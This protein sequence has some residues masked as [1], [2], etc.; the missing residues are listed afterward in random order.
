[1]TSSKNQE[2]DDVI[3]KSRNR[4]LGH[5]RTHK[6]TESEAKGNSLRSC[7]RSTLVEKSLL[8]E[9]EKGFLGGMWKS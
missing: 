3:K 8:D 2:I 9:E 1:M 4:V 7:D 6:N 5:S